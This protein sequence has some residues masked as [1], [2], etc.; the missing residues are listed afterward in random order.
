MA[1][2]DADDFGDLYSLLEGANQLAT[3]SPGAVGL[4]GQD[5]THKTT[6]EIVELYIGIQFLNPPVHVESL[7]SKR[8]LN[9][10]DISPQADPSR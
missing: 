7:A 8:C 2:A 5:D 3:R 1:T 10:L 4:V 6:G 9:Y